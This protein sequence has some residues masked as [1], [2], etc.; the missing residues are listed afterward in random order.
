MSILSPLVSFFIIM[1]FIE[2]LSHRWLMHYPLLG[3]S[4]SIFKEHHIEHRCRGMLK[5][6]HVDMHPGQLNNG[7]TAGFILLVIGL[8]D[9]TSAIIWSVCLLAYCYIW[10]TVH[11]SSHGRNEK[12]W[13]SN[14][15]YGKKM[16]KHHLRHHDNF[17]SNFG[18]VFLHTDYLFGTKN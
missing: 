6:N 5:S 7:I 10:T 9:S 12:H 1:P 17:N 11:R 2:Y 15:W 4:N 3:K 8:I 16:I 13:I 14:T 18:T